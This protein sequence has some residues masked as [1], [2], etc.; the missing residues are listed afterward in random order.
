MAHGFGGLG[1]RRA[2]RGVGTPQ[3]DVAHLRPDYDR[4]GPRLPAGGT[5][6]LKIRVLE[7]LAS[8][9]RAGAERVAVA[10]ACGLDRSRFETEVISLKPAFPGGFEP[11][12]EDCGVP[13]GH[14]GE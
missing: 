12:L 1:R 6:A 3:A 8:L 10:I 7:V 11:A 14:L 13:V 4:L 5:R 2:H 9:R